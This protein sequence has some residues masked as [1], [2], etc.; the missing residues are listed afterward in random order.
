[1]F[2]DVDRL[3]AVNDE[4]GH[5]CGDRV[6]AVDQIL[7]RL[8]GREQVVTDGLVQIELRL[9]GDVAHPH[10]LGQ[11]GRAVEVLIDAGHDFEQGGLAGTIGAQNADLG[12]GEEGQCDV[13]KNV[14]LGRH[15]LAEPVHGK[16]VLG[17]CGTVNFR[18]VKPALSTVDGQ[19]L[20]KQPP[21]IHLAG[22]R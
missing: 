17:H 9:L 7:D 16:D 13:F 10:V 12:A 2:V 6:E 21:K 5:A 18:D 19:Q 3:K 8:H 4:L 20:K 14:A 15:D 1:M 11:V 22:R